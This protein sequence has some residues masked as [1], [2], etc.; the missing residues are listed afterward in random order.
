MRIT[1]D[2]RKKKSGC[3]I[4]LQVVMICLLALLGGLNALAQSTTATIIGNVTDST[5]AAITTATIT[6]TNLDTKQPTVLTT[7]QSGEY[8]ADLLPVGHYQVAVNAKGFKKFVQ[9]NITLTVD[10]LIRVDVVLGTGSESE[11]ITVTAEPPQLN[12]D[13]AT[14]GNTVESSEVNSLPLVDRNVYSLLPLVAGVQNQTNGNTL[15]YPQQVVQINGGTTSNNNGT[16]SYYLDGGLNMTAARNTGNILPNPEAISEFNVQTSNYNATYGRMSSGV[17]N[18]LTKSGTDQFHGSTYEFNRNTDFNATPFEAT[19][20]QPFHRNMF[21]GVL[22]GPAVHEKLFF[23][24]EY[25][26]L[27]QTTSNPVNSAVLPTAAEAVGNFSAFLPTASGAITSC[28]QTLAAADTAAKNFIVCNPTTRTPFANNIITTALD[29]TAVNILKSLPAANT[30]VG[31]LTPGFN[32]FIPSKT[33]W[34]EYMAKGDY[35][36]SSRQRVEAM[37]FRNWGTTTIQAGGGNIPWAYQNQQ[38]AQ[39]NVNLSDT[40]TI[41]DNKINQAWMTYTRIFGARANSPQTSLTSF[42]SNFAIQGMPN[43]PQI[44]VTGYFTLSNTIGGPEAGTDFYS[45]RDMFIYNKG[46]HSL[47]L[48][49]EMSLNKDIIASNLNNYGVFG[50][51][52]STTARTGNAL[53]DFVLGMQASQTQDAPVVALDN[54]FFYSLFAQDDWRILPHLTINTGMRWD[55][56]TTPTDPQNKESMFVPG[57]QSTTNPN[58]PLGVVVVGDQGVTRGSVPTRYQH[59]S[60]RLGLAWD[61]FGKGKT[62]VRASAGVFWGSVS[63]NEWSATSN[64]YPFSLRYTFPKVGTLTNPYLNSPSPFPYIYTPGKVNAIV[65]GGSVE[66]VQPSFQWPYT[67]QLTASVQQQVTKNLVV[68]A[69]Y[70]GSLARDIS[71]SRDIN[72]PVFNATTP[73]ANTTGN[74][75]ARRP[76]DTGVLGQILQVQSNQTA[77]YHGLQV[78]FSQR[79]SKGFSFSGFYAFSK[80][81]DSNVLDSN[82]APE[83]YSQPQFEKGPSNFNQKHTYTTTLIWQPNYYHGANHAVKAVADGWSLSTIVKLASGLPFSVTTGKDNNND[84]N[85]TDRA[86]QTGAFYNPSVDRKSRAALVQQYFNPASFCSYSVSAPTVCPGVGPAGSDGSSERNGYYGPAQRDVDMALF[87][88]FNIFRAIKLQARAEVTN[89]FNMVSLNNPNATLSSATVG[90]ITSAATMREIQLSFRMTF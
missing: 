11:T 21:G 25:T 63:G 49:G 34:N 82:A 10:L 13:N 1:P 16:V 44:T 78:T 84:G 85:T 30:G 43:L 90:K 14:I 6:V 46:K 69:A 33:D 47:S 59:L 77:N 52:G 3:S 28:S 80:T 45:G 42:G 38:W 15:G 72:Y 65:T 40:F 12:M 51:S 17:V 54:S 32:G 79:L 81:L 68:T 57:Q 60:P 2:V 75:L 50:F 83:D 41:S 23:F 67:Y 70:V 22:G 9:E 61:P 24:G 5:G 20:K 53:A 76:Y 39:D 4:A 86:N 56:Q 88:N 27:R 48:G 66:G 74:V 37:F 89:A 71:F 8:R 19:T 35:Q 31:T 29:P 36:L 62:S 58:M 26:G 18:A 73:T 55:V 87:R 64:Y 7:N